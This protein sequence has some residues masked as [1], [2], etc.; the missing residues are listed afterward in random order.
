VANIYFALLT[1]ALASALFNLQ[2]TA[3][4]LRGPQS[5]LAPTFVGRNLTCSESQK[6]FISKP[7][8]ER[9][10]LKVRLYNLLRESLYDD[11]KGVVNIA[12]EKEIKAPASSRTKGHDNMP[13]PELA[14]TLCNT[15]QVL[16]CMNALDRW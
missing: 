15:R 7:F 2:A 1:M 14:R 13:R 6:L 10:K 8:A 16:S 4:T 12:R 3:Q 9:A 11:A 5:D